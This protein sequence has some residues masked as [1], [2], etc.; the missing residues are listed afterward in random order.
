MKSHD[1]DPEVS[2]GIDCMNFK[3]TKQRRMLEHFQAT[4]G[5]FY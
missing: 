5:I 2:D 1:R 3:S 4:V